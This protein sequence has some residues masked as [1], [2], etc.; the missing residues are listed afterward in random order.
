[1]ICVTGGPYVLR[2]LLARI[3]EFLSVLLDIQ[4]FPNTM[5]GKDTSS[6]R[7]DCMCRWREL[8]AMISKH[9]EILMSED[10][11]I[12]RIYGPPVRI[13]LPLPLP[14][15]TGLGFKGGIAKE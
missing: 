11:N 6:P 8:D 13:S 2:L 5:F 12:S 15:L 9:L 1:M 7:T 10:R 4:P 14:H 3:Y